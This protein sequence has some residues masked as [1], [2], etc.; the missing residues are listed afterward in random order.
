M[1]TIQLNRALVKACPL[2]GRAALPLSWLRE[3]GK[4][5]VG[6]EQ[7][8]GLCDGIHQ[9]GCGLWEGLS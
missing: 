7:P 9:G 6:M 5:G 1:A 2:V 4:E 8:P 3:V